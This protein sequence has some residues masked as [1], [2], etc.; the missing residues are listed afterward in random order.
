MTVRRLS[1]I[2]DVVCL[3]VCGGGWEVEADERRWEAYSGGDGFEETAWYSEEKPHRPLVHTPLV[4]A[5]A[6]KQPEKKGEGR[7][8]RTKGPQAAGKEGGGEKIGGREEPAGELEKKGR[9]EGGQKAR[10]SWEKR[11]REKIA[12]HTPAREPGKTEWEE[13]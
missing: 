9:G 2:G 5:M 3:M 10:A 7:K 12:G 6:R 13:N 8:L 1:E 4:A 11:E